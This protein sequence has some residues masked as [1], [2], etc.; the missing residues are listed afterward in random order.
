[1]IV[2]FTIAFKD[3]ESLDINGKTALNENLMEDDVEKQKLMND[4]REEL[5]KVL[6]SYAIHT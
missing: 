6:K 3:A 5:I 1:M 2:L 4:Y